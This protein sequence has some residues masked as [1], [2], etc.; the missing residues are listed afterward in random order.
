MSEAVERLGAE[1]SFGLDE[2]LAATRGELA[3][4]GERVRFTGV[5]TDTRTL[6]PGELFVAIRGATWD[7]HQYLGEAARRGAGA[8]LGER[9]AIDQPLGCGV[10]V[11]RES[12][13]ALGD[14][15]AFHRR[16]RQAHVLAVAGS[17]GKTTTKEMAA[18]IL[19]EAFGAAA[20]LQTRGTQNNLVGLP[21]TLLRLG[22]SQRVAVVELGMNGP[23]EVWRL[24]EIAEPDAGVITC[25]APEHLEGVGSLHGA[26]EAEAELF[27][28][29]RPSAT[30]VVNADDPLV[31]AAAE[32]FPGRIVRFGTGGDV[33]A[34]EVSDGGLEGSRFSLWVGAAAS[35]VHL[36]V[37]GRHNV[38]NALAAAALASIA[39][40]RLDHIRAALERFE[41]PSMRM[42]V[43]RL[44]SG[45]TVINDAYNAN[46]ASMAAA[47]HTLA[48]SAA[49]RRVAVLG[50]MR[51]LGA[52][53]ESAHAE[54]GRTAAAAALDL[55]VVLGEHATLVRNG[56]VAAGM[57]PERIV[58]A[59]D[60]AEAGARLRDACRSG[61]L[62]LLKGSRGASLEAV[63]AHLAGKGDA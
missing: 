33:R 40:A 11:V 21:L 48:A 14:L 59:V 37:P 25:V 34:D 18:A 23:G 13:A 9:E 63:L 28:R 15:A 26:A 3:R 4:L 32:A 1:T 2:V 41:A 17:N 44:P 6:R 22:E 7:G 61:D 10:V 35:R 8:V 12:L 52:E 62:V 50:E 36:P 55:L 51:E 29:L 45:I 47:L 39:G 58:L 38:A 54:L 60:H 30:A 43:E 20:V 56:A 42:Q 27:R 24:A 31:V 5:T 19:R 57:A 46:P 49:T 16:R 53:T